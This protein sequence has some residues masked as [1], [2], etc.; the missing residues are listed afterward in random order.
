MMMAL[1]LVQLA[2][3]IALLA[4]M[5]FRPA[6]S[7]VGL[8]TQLVGAVLGLAG[9]AHVGLWLFPP[10]WLPH[11]A[12]AGIVMAAMWHASHRTSRAMWPERAIGWIG[13][14]ALAGLGVLGAAIAVKAHLARQPPAGSA[15]FDLA[16]PLASGRY[17]VANG[18]TWLLINAH[19]ESIDSTVVR[20]RPWR[21]NG[22]AVDIVAI[23]AL[24]MRTRGAL[25]ADPADYRIF[26]VAVLA[27]CAGSVIAAV[28]ELPDMNVP[29]YDRANTAGNHVM[30]D[31]NGVHVVLAHLK[32]GTVGV[33]AGEQIATGDVIGAVGNSGGTSEPHLHIHAQRPGPP[34]AP[35]GGDPLPIRLHGRFLVRGDRVH[36]K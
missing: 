3:P 6:R 4:W 32:R 19:R 2:V 33:T 10:W 29:E 17:L 34:G 31:C 36:V 14:V 9:I 35:M 24:G 26:G 5:M 7:A 8:A 30:L 22:H 12:A 11:V 18:G 21:G 28:D 13:V 1:F 25:P 20:L 23:D 15:V 27:P 16:F